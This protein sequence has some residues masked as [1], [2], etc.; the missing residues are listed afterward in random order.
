MK[1]LFRTSWVSFR[2]GLSAD[3][4]LAPPPLP[5]SRDCFANKNAQKWRQVVKSSWILLISFF[6]CSKEK[7][8]PEAVVWLIDLGSVK[9]FGR[10]GLF[11]TQVCDFFSPHYPLLA[12]LYLCQALSLRKSRQQW[13]LSK[14]DISRKVPDSSRSSKVSKNLYAGRT[15]S[16]TLRGT[17]LL[18]SVVYEG[19]K[20]CPSQSN[21]MMRCFI[22]VRTAKQSKEVWE[23]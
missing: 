23:N 13:R 6:L 14:L 22:Q 15:R 3:A 17:T 11:T 10:H 12:P 18:Q 20:G 19:V 8:N 1:V 7:Y 4:C 2:R 16:R 21:E 5:L 9:L